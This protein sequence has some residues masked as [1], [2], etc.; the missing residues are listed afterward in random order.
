M[1]S[2][3]PYGLLNKGIEPTGRDISFIDNLVLRVQ[4]LKEVGNLPSVSLTRTLPDGGV[5]LVRDMGGNLRVITDKPEVS[6]SYQIIHT[7]FAHGYVPSF[8]SGVVLEA[9][10][11]K[12]NPFVSIR[13]TEQCRRRLA[14]Y[15]PNL[16]SKQL[17]L[18]RLAVEYGN[19]GREFIPK[20]PARW[21]HSQYAKQRA[22][23]Y[24][25]AM[26]EVIQ[27]VGGYGR[28]DFD[29]LPAKPEE[30]AVISLPDDVA[31]DILK[32]I[33]DEILPAYYGNPPTDGKYLYDYKFS[34]TH[35]VAI[36]G[37]GTP[38]L[39][40]ISPRGVYVMPLPLIPATTTAAFR[41]Y[42]ERVSDEEVIKILDRFGGL[43]SGEGFPIHPAAFSAWER[44]GV[45][46]RIS[47]TSE[48]YSHSA[49]AT[50]IGWSANRD[51]TEIAN[52]CYD[53]DDTTGYGIG[54][55]FQ[56][57]L[58]IGEVSNFGRIK[59][60][61]LSS[62]K[63]DE[64]RQKIAVYIAEVLR[65]FD[66]S[67]AESLSV[68]YKLRRA[69]ISQIKARLSE[70]FDA[71][72]EREYWLNLQ[73]KPIASCSG[74]VVQTYKGGLVSFEKFGYQPQIKFPEPLIGGCI[75]H[76]FTPLKRNKDF[77]TPKPTDTPVFVYFIGDDMKTAKYYRNWG[78]YYQDVKSDF[79][80]I[81]IVGSWMKE[82]TYGRS[83]LHGNFYTTDIDKRKELAEGYK[84]TEIVGRDRGYDTK[85]FFSFDSIFWRPGSIW[86]NRYYTHHAK[87]YERYQARLKVGLCV[88][89]FMRNALL[90]AV[91]E[92]AGSET[93][94]DA[95]SLHHVR[96]PYSYRYWTY[97]KIWAWAGGLPNTKGTPFPK[98]GS[99]VWVEYEEYRPTAVSD[100]A[101]SG[102]W[103]QGF[104]QDYTWLVHPDNHSWQHSGGGGE[105]KV[106]TYQKSDTKNGVS[107]SELQVSM[108]FKPEVLHDSPHPQYFISSPD[109]EVGLI[110]YRDGCKN[111][112]GN[113][114]YGS[115]S[116]YQKGDESTRIHW[117]ETALISD[118]SKSYCFIGV[119]NE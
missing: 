45:I 19:T 62:V 103:I 65:M 2:P 26:A 81:M 4:T 12:D 39:V 89:F 105:P 59:K 117:N 112:I 118:H 99:P 9:I 38:W 50:T 101:D 17:A 55:L 98:D 82:E 54:F 3:R 87:T 114:E 34:S 109:P 66:G 78:E 67:G 92:V 5:V 57:N 47:D 86:R 61:D 93:K 100:F 14:S 42:M 64:E 36:G 91:E 104:P 75:S 96:D 41:S 83:G 11:P 88:P 77:G 97:H 22:T 79:E 20:N 13:I 74:R 15:S 63:D 43:P 110:F 6:E 44:A 27:V 115:I 21:L 116:E 10:V 32:E 37:D 108:Y 16:P 8:Y 58:G 56:L 84:R 60:A 106:K 24:S 40:H 72:T 51:G 25:G 53:Y 113:N 119:I 49:Y 76:D 71:P 18:N 30:R 29:A 69:A 48:F 7:G 23:W 33:G 90:H 52:T 1:A 94:S 31:A 28:Q 70:K 102:P 68:R 73:M 95:V 35:L 107:T 80:D 46:I 111:M 85:P